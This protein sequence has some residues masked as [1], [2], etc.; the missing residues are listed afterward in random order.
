METCRSPL[1]LLCRA[2]EFGRRLWS[3]YD[4]PFSRHDFTRPQL[5]ACLVVRES[6]KL[7]YRKT[8]AFLADVPDWRA[9]IHMTGVPDHNTL[10][11]A[12]GTM[13]KPRKIRRALDLM[14]DDAGEELKVGLRE[15]PLTI[16]STC[17]ESRHRSRHYDRVCRKIDLKPGEKYAKRPGKYGKSVNASRSKK[18]RSMPKLAL[19]TVAALHQILAARARIGNGSDALDFEPLLFDAWC[20]APVKD[21]AADTGYD[22]EDNHRIARLDMGVRSVIPPG[23][24]RPTTK[25]PTGRY[26]RLMKQR[27]ARKADARVYGQRAQSETVNSMIKRNL[28]D[29]LRSIKTTRRKQ[30][31]LLRTLV[32]NLMLGRAKSED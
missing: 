4:S 1:E 5:F 31:M 11:R 25:A 18:L 24:G 26:R 10:W 13:L 14:A 17:F 23:I 22:S 7:S 30:E 2:Y 32:H 20:R 19:A 16:D 27:F 21:A 28:G 8:E 29:C 9:E 12:F 6:L 15:K 3:D